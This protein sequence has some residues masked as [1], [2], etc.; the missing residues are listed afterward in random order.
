MLPRSF[1]H[2]ALVLAM[3]VPASGCLRAFQPTEV[4][5]PASCDALLQRAGD[6]G[7]GGFSAGEAQQVTFCQQQRILRAEET[8]AQFARY[9]ARS[10]RNAGFFSAASAA[11]AILAFVLGRD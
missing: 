5:V 9:Q 1:R 2:T 3:S 10:L 8:Q 11:A 7:V 6:Q 4:P